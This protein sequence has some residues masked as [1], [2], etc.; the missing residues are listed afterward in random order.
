MTAKRFFSGLLF[1][2]LFILL[3]DRIIG[4]LLEQGIYKYFDLHS[5]VEYL[6]IGSSPATLDI[7]K[8]LIEEQTGSKFAF[9]AQQGATSEDRLVMI[10]HFL[11]INKSHLKGVI[12]ELTPHIFTCHGLS[13]NSY[14]L[15]YPYLGDS[16]IYH[17]IKGKSPSGI[18]FFLK[19]KLMTARFNDATLNFAL[20][21]LVNSHRNLKTGV[22]DI[23]A[24]QREVDQDNFWKIEID[25]SCVNT[26]KNTVN[27]LSDRKINAIYIFFPI[28]PVVT[29]KE[30]LVVN[31]VESEVEGI[32]S[33][34]D[35]PIILNYTHLLDSQPRYF[36]DHLH[37]N[38][39]GQAAFTEQLTGDLR[40]INI[41][42]G[43][44]SL[45]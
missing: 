27:F 18:E 41:T 16:I 12:Y 37:L 7:D 32:V 13:S 33:V 4:E 44:D 2:I 21:G 1:F 36:Y 42:S 26:F 43:S 6:V 19:R 25:S 3:I 39:E 28:I 35:R 9:Y 10:K 34:S 23:A 8:K 40:Q 30:P 14:N 31:L 29:A 11:S 22:A 20:R 17:Y 45:K 5:K 15:L 24:L 38:K